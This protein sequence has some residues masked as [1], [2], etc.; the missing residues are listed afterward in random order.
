MHVAE[1]QVVHMLYLFDIWSVQ[2]QVD[3]KVVVQV[4]CRSVVHVGTV[5]EWYISQ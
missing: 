4:G 5:L 2:V 1:L 3:C